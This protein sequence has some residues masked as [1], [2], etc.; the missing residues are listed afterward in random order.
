MTSGR[1]LVKSYFHRKLHVCASRLMWNENA[2][3]ET[4]STLNSVESRTVQSTALFHN[5]WYDGNCK[6]FFPLLRRTRVLRIVRLSPFDEAFNEHASNQRILG[7]TT[8][9]IPRL[10]Y[11]RILRKLIYVFPSSFEAINVIDLFNRWAFDS[12][13]FHH[14]SPTITRCPFCSFS[15][16]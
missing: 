5:T 7:D 9:L 6:S 8:A 14:P 2:R 13:F 1:H 16:D 3:S 4:L 12:N 15:T 11:C 10:S